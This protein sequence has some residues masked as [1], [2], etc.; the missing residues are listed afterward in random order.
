[1]AR[2]VTGVKKKKQKTWYPVMLPKIFGGTQIA[3]TLSLDSKNIVGR[4][5]NTVLSDVTG[6]I[7]HFH[8]TVTLRIKDVTEGKAYTEYNGQNLISDKIA[9]M[10]NRWRSRIDSVDDISTK[11]GHKLRIKTIVITRQR[12]N[13]TTKADIRKIVSSETVKYCT[14]K[15]LES[16]VNDIFSGKLQKHV[17]LSAK[18]V[19]PLK[20]VEVRKTEILK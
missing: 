6:D 3:E 9:R 4:K 13:T 16:I 7:K 15:S 8:T 10:V 18:K 20:S 2:A 5:I 14:D 1:M 17:F 11:D 12:V 19:Y